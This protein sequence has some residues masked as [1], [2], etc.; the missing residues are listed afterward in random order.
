LKN[1]QKQRQTKKDPRKGLVAISISKTRTHWPGRYSFFLPKISEKMLPRLKTRNK[2]LAKKRLK[3]CL[4]V[5]KREETLKIATKKRKKRA[6]LL[7][8]EE[9][10]GV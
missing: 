2:P 9:N 8:W 3:G 6:V 4:L 5:R 1:A 10:D 7:F